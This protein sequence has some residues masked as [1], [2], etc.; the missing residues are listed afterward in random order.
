[1]SPGTLMLS[2]L[3]WTLVIFS[4]GLI[5]LSASPL[6]PNKQRKKWKKSSFIQS[7]RRYPN[8]KSKIFQIYIKRLSDS[9]VVWI[10][11]SR[12]QIKRQRPVRAT[13]ASLFH[14]SIQAQLDHYI[15]SIF[16]TDFCVTS[17]S[18]LFAFLANIINHKFC[19]F[20]TH[21][22]ILM[23]NIN[24]GGGEKFQWKTKLKFQRGRTS[25]ATLR[26]AFRPLSVPFV[27]GASR[28]GWDGWQWCWTLHWASSESAKP[29]E[30]PSSEAKYF[31]EFFFS[32]H[33][34]CFFF[35]TCWSLS[36]DTID[37]SSKPP[38]NRPNK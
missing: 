4:S 33:F 24:S 17:F 27:F 5:F 23:K 19:K 9:H 29:G 14:L 34:F 10:V 18:F 25:R 6:P 8:L 36:T 30:T 35:S 38:Q 26:V 12:A 15:N 37:S 21:R 2:L 3:C 28:L 32:F 20:W 13:A 1:M 31:R 11:C 16:Q 7:S 22:E